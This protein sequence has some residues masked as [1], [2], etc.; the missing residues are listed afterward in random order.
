MIRTL[1]IVSLFLFCLSGCSSIR[2]VE[3]P[4]PIARMGST[5]IIDGVFQPGE[6]DDA[7]IVRV[8]AIEQFKMKHD[9]V[10]LYLAVKAG[11]GNLWFDTDRGLRVLHWSAQLGSAEYMK[12]DTLTQSL[13]KPFDFELWGLQD[14]SPAVIQETLAGYLAENGW[15]ANTASMG[16]LMQS[17]LAVSFDWLGVTAGSGRFFEIPGVRIAAGPMISRGDPRGEELMKRPREEIDRLYPPVS[18]PAESGL[19][20]SLFMRGCPETIS[21]DPEDFGEIW[22]DLRR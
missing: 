21:V 19:E 6:W 3:P 8:G 10:N 20:N 22:I 1:S 17:E 15:A 7:G 18:W 4:G 16:N 12:S 13:D 11:G 2:E 5:P 14:E 9:G